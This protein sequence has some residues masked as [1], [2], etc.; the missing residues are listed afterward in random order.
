VLSSAI[1][2]LYTSDACK[3]SGRRY[4]CE[5]K[6]LE[7]RNSYTLQQQGNFSF[8]FFKNVYFRGSV[9]QTGTRNMSSR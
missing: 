5:L 9:G 6:F 1:I 3:D 8:Y 4:L 2:D 7:S